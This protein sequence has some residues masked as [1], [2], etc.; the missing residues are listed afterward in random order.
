MR[1]EKE[2][3]GKGL[4]ELAYILDKRQSFISHYHVTNVE[5]S[6][7]QKNIYSIEISLHFAHLAA[8][9][10][11]PDLHT[12]REIVL[13]VNVLACWAQTGTQRYVRSVNTNTTTS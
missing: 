13:F 6:R 11:S 12:L 10:A 1:S 7:K 9:E 2:R 4:L 5:F 8:L 3:K